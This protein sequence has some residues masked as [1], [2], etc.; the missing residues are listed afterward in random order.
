MAK[1]KESERRSW[2]VSNKHKVFKLSQLIRGWI[3]C[4]KIGSMKGLCREMD[5]HI[6]Y[7]LRMCIRKRLKTLEDRAKNLMKQGVPRWAAFNV[8]YTG[9]R[10][11]RMSKN[12]WVDKAIRNKRL[13]AYGLI[14]MSDY[15][16]RDVSFVKL[17]EPPYAERHAR[18]CGR[19]GKYQSSR[20]LDLGFQYGKPRKNFQNK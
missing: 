5:S 12:G 19:S 17:I 20:M 18:W 8:A 14:S 9:N 13:A 4:F 3:N 15:T 6:R 16:P 10:Y 2:G 1:A 7:R 11:A